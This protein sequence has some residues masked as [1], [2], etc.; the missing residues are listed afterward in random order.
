LDTFIR[1]DFIIRSLIN[2][3]SIPTAI[4][5]RAISEFESEILNIRK[6]ILPIKPT[7]YSKIIVPNDVINGI[8]KDLLTVSAPPHFK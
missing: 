5:S 4:G 7:I 1:F 3:T 6:S 2:P 8:Q